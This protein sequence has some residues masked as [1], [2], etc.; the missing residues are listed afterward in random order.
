MAG[1]MWEYIAKTTEKVGSMLE[2]G[3]HL[4]SLE[5]VVLKIHRCF[6]PGLRLGLGLTLNPNYFSWFYSDHMA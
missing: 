5:I 4:F 6:Q 1:L 3:S 2:N